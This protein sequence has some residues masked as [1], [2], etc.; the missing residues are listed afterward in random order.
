[1]SAAGLSST[2]RGDLEAR[3]EIDHI[4]KWLGVPWLTAEITPIE[5]VWVI[6]AKGA[7][8]S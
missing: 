8:E 3:H 2:G 7:A 5:P 4:E 1:M 6:P